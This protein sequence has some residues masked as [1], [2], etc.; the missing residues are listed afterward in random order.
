[1]TSLYQLDVAQLS[2]WQ[3]HARVR[4]PQ[5][6]RARS[7]DS[8]KGT[9][10]TLAI[11]GGQV[12]MMGSIVLAGRA[13][14]KSGCGKVWLGFRQP[15][16]PLPVLPEQPEIMLATADALRHRGD[17]TAWVMG[18]GW[19]TEAAAVQMLSDMLPGVAGMP[20][21]L[22]ADA[23]N[24]LAQHPDIIPSDALPRCAPLIITP[25]PAEAGR[26]LHQSAADIQANR[27]CAAVQL[28]ARYRAWVVLKGHHTLVA[29]PQGQVE[30]NNSG[31]AGLATAG[32]GDVLSGIIGSLLAQRVAVEQAVSGGV[33]LHGAAAEILAANEIGPVGLC[34]GELADAVRWLRNQLV[35]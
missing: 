18:C 21:L 12:G 25:H 19:G 13:A 11:V 35:L 23:L 26:L 10:G 17:V 27:Y 7:E 16:L 20:L 14:L 34:A 33:W 29:S 15:S 30:Q 5:L 24:I 4:F 32:S 31:N 2:A 28:A 1:M 9:F 8:H 22:D 6:C 3:Q